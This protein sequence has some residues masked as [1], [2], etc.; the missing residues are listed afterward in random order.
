MGKESGKGKME[1][2]LVAG[3]CDMLVYEPKQQTTWQLTGFIC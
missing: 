2:A 1:R 3:K